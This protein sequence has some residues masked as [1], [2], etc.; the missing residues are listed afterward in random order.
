MNYI[1][2]A[3]TESV[4]HES[5]QGDLLGALGIDG[6]LLILQSLAFLILVFLLGKFVY[7]HLI[8][9][10]DARREAIEAGLAS[11]KK[12]E[13]ALKDV[14]EKVAEITKKAR[15]EANEIVQ[16]SQKEAADIVSA[17]EEKAL[18]RAEHIIEEAKAQMS[19]ELAAAREVLKKDTAKLVALATERVI[20]EK[21]DANKDAQ[22]IDSA[23]NAAQEN[24][25]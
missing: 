8:K 14:E 6:K 16:H 24:E 18:K 2:F 7:P 5:S 15:T 25:S 20:K 22:L 23:I 19:N 1:F 17:A 4:Q 10:I 3:A 11:A 21:V 13:Q 12:S 9:A